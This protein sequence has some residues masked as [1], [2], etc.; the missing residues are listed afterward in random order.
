VVADFN[1]FPIGQ[2]AIHW[3]GKPTHPQI[4]DIQSL[5]VFP[6]FQGMGI[7]SRLVQAC[8]QLVRER[9]YKQISLSVGVENPRARLLYERLGYVVVGETYTDTWHF[10]DA[11]GQ[12][13]HVSELIIDMVKPL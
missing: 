9:E 4:P 2:A 5:R 13:R 7:G 11:Q 8:E 3:Q 12:V 10:T 1:N 6:A